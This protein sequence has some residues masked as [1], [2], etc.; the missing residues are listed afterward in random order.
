MSMQG[1][2]CLVTGATSGLGEVTALALAQMGA[3]VIIVSRVEEKCRR[4]VEMIQDQTGNPSVDYFR[5]DL[6]SQ[7]EIRDLAG[8]VKNEYDRLDV[9]VNNAGGFF[10][11][12]QESVDSIEMTFA[13]NHLNYFLLTNLLLEILEKSPSARI[14]NVSSGG[15][16]NQEIDFGNLQMERNYIHFTAYG[17]S[18]LANLYFTYEMDRRLDGKPITVNAVNPGYTASNIA[19]EGNLFG[20]I[21]MP[22][23]RIIA[24][25]TEKGAETIIYLASSEEVEGISG[26]YYQDKKAI[27]SSPTSYEVETAERLWI[28][29]EQL[30]GLN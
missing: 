10:W 19:R 9:L 24:N 18:K 11:G 22:L 1:K 20:W 25:S 13:L 6:S 21:F 2:R 29:S 12:R 8:A 23:T 26:K 14:V 15:H 16:N 7:N 3:E 27:P 5:A 17:K 30:T 28:I 4:T